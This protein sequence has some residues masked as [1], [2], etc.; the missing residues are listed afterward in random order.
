VLDRAF[1]PRLR[2][3]LGLPQSQWINIENEF[4]ASTQHHAFCNTVLIV[5]PGR[6]SAA[7]ASDLS[8]PEAEQILRADWPIV[9]IHPSRRPTLMPLRIA[10]L[11]RCAQV[12]L[13]RNTDDLLILL[14]SLRDTTPGHAPRVA[15]F[16]RPGTPRMTIRRL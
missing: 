11:C 2:L 6:R 12:Q 10:N 3:G 7:H 8:R 16:T 15:L 1:P 9:D 14:D 4:P 13:S 5:E